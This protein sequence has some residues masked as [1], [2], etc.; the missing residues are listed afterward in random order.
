LG[1]FGENYIIKEENQNKMEKQSSLRQ[2]AFYRPDEVAQI[3]HLFRG[4]IYR[5]IRDGRLSGS[6]FGKGPWRVSYQALTTLLKLK[7]GKMTTIKDKLICPKEAADRLTV[8]KSTI[9]RWFWEGK[10]KGIHI[11]GR[12][13]RILESAIITIER[14]GEGEEEHDYESREKR[15]TNK[16]PAS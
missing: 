8:S 11:A 2:R 1:G 7:E 16:T 10:L 14:E 3:L 5:M 15:F 13:V 6:K 4:T 9:Y 12:T